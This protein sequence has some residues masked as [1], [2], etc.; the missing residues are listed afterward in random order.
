VVRACLGPKTVKGGS[1][2]LGT[3]TLADLVMH[4]TSEDAGSL[5][6]MPWVRPRLGLVPGMVKRNGRGH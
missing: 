6:V 1:L 5:A 4:G 3:S 2:S